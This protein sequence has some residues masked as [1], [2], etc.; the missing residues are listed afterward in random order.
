MSIFLAVVL[1][2]SG[3]PSG[4]AAADA[5]PLTK[6]DATPAKAEA[7]APVARSGREL[8]DAAHAALRKWAKANDKEADAAA[9]DLLGIYCELQQDTQLARSTRESLRTTV[10]ARLDQLATQIG[11]RIAKDKAV[12]K[13]DGAKADA[14][15]QSVAAAGNPAPLAQ[16]GVPA[17]GGG[18]GGGQQNAADNGQALVDLIV[19][20][21]SPK[22]WD[23][24]GG[25]A[26]IYYWQQ[27]HA[28]VVRAT[29]EVH[30]EISDALD[31]LNRATH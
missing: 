15:V 10:R 5:T 12:A 4:G 31:Q 21:I 19:N 3:N 6:A 29:S 1:T 24:N 7:K 14:K 23:V 2:V 16:V 11:K 17:G 26:T 28:I 8:A 22:S 20:T 13:A 27:Q 9:R 30:G 18:Y 25:N